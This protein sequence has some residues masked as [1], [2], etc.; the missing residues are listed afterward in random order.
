M[1]N[2]LMSVNINTHFLWRFVPVGGLLS[3]EGLTMGGERLYSDIFIPLY[4]LLK[5]NNFIQEQSKLFWLSRREWFQS[6]QVHRL[7]CLHKSA[8]KTDQ[9]QKL[10]KKS[11]P[12][13]NFFFTQ[14][15]FYSYIHNPLALKE[16][17]GHGWKGRDPTKQW[18]PTFTGS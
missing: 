13:G 2:Y 9:N 16:K 8:V 12:K 6:W 3:T 11:I 1:G 18:A 15:S 7:Q 10:R 17:S 4:C 5:P 14:S